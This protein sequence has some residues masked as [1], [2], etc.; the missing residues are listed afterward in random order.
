MT[1]CSVK[2]VELPP[3]KGGPAGGRRSGG[4]RFERG[5]QGAG[6]P[7]LRAGS[8]VTG[9]RPPRQTRE[10]GVFIANVVLQVGFALFT[11]RL[12]NPR[13]A[14]CSRGCH[15][16]FYLRRCLVC[17]GSLQRRNKTQRVCRKARCRNAWRA[18]A[19]F[20]RYSPS[21]SVSSAS[22]TPDFADQKGPLKS[23]RAAPDSW[24]ETVPLTT[25][26]RT[27]R[28]QGS[29]RRSTAEKSPPLAEA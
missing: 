21:N 22:K 20:G 18:R 6:L 17:E 28:R 13:E 9:S 4:F 2:V 19:G 27:G 25:A 1:V 15:T 8:R 3:P 11:P 12:D 7:G 14:F 24:P 29:G 26:L 10:R 23:D 5:T 16:S